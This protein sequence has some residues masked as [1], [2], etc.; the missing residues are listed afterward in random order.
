MKRLRPLDFLAPPARPWA[1]YILL[2]MAGATLVGLAW[3]FWM[4][5]AP[6]GVEPLPRRQ[7]AT[8][9]APPAEP[10]AVALSLPPAASGL[11]PVV[12]AVDL[13]PPTAVGP[14]S[15]AAQPQA[16]A[17]AVP[18]AASDAGLPSAAASQAEAGRATDAQA[19][20]AL[21]AMSDAYADARYM[22]EQ[23]QLRQ[24]R[25][26]GGP[27]ALPWADILAVLQAHLHGGVGLVGLGPDGVVATPA[28]RVR[29]TARAADDARMRAYVDA[30]QAD[31]RLHDVTLVSPV[32]AEP[33]GSGLR[34][35]IVLGWRG[36]PDA[37]RQGPSVP[38]RDVVSRP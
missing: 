16:A 4:T 17:S 5:R 1:G 38:A 26:L 2:M 18:S 29:M 21:P 20:P 19:V 24:T 32:L 34:F 25:A 22:R 31:S 15:G 6:D 14:A 35:S 7:S 11:R 33:D 3:V 10:P 37:P 8:E 23:F 36:N 12:A 13:V 27:Q 9:S 28:G 30:L